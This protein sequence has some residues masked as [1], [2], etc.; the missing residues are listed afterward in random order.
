MGRI[1]KRESEM[2][3]VTRVDELSD[4]LQAVLIK[5]DLKN[6]TSEEA[7]AYYRTVCKSL[8]LNPY[9]KPFEYLVLSGRTV[10]YATRNCSDQLR[11]IYGVNIELG[12]RRISDGL[13][14]IQAKAWDAAGR[15]DEDI[16][17]V[18]YN[19]KLVGDVRSNQ[20]MKCVTKAKR[21]V[22]LSI[23]G[24][25]WLDETEV[26]T[27]PGAQAPKFANGKQPEVSDERG[28][29]A[30]VGEVDQGSA[31]ETDRQSVSPDSDR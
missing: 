13:L 27:I 18:P 25:G 12:E 5:G 26:E 30:A 20:L 21:R 19:E 22:T 24:L 7:V 11:K 1:E 14:T 10:L 4:K 6:L 8:G 16:G 31:R 17:A 28:D 29:R 3:E 2:N 9:T 15:K 23:C